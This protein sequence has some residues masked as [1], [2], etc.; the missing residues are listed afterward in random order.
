MALRVRP[1]AN[2]QKKVNRSC[3]ERAKQNAITSTNMSIGEECLKV[4]IE[5]GLNNNVYW[6]ALG[7]IQMLVRAR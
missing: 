1:N 5:F 2:L 6:D 7:N 4:S 3:Q